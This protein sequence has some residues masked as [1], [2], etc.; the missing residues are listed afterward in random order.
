[1]SDASGERATA[2]NDGIGHGDHDLMNS[3]INEFDQPKAIVAAIIL[4]FAGTGVAMG[5][6]M[7]VGSLAESLSFN[8]QQLGWLASSDMGGLFIGSFVTALVV[9]RAKLTDA[10]RAALI[11]HEQQCTWWAH[12]TNMGNS[13]ANFIFDEIERLKKDPSMAS[14]FKIVIFSQ[15]LS[16]LNSLGDKLLRRYGHKGPPTPVPVPT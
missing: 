4:G 5:M 13:K 14:K 12:D 16:T 11:N 7:L 3:D 8:E 6:P 15:Y 2:S 1:M 10:Q 9:A